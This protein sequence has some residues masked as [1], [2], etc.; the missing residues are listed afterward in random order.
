MGFVQLSQPLVCFFIEYSLAIC[1][2]FIEEI[3]SLYLSASSYLKMDKMY[4][5]YIYGGAEKFFPYTKKGFQSKTKSL[6]CDEAT[7]MDI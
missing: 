5:R 4:M 2:V 1:L 3:H 6:K 7:E